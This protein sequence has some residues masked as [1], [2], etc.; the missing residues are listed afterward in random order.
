M[1]AS[2]RSD[3]PTERTTEWRGR[4]AG[5]PARTAGW[6]AL[7]SPPTGSPCA[8]EPVALRRC[9]SPRTGWGTA[10]LDLPR[11]YRRTGR[12]ASTSTPGRRH[13]TARARRVPRSGSGARHPPGLLSGGREALLPTAAGGPL[14][15]R[16][17]DRTGRA[18]DRIARVILRSVAPIPAAP[19][20][21]RRVG[22]ARVVLS[23]PAAIMDED[24]DTTF[25]APER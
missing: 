6:T 22:G 11:W 12:G 7:P 5:R 17:R 15:G 23:V 18:R 25:E 13:D 3:N 14:A 20:G 24:A 21:L 1:T 19:R 9:G 16:A 4:T 10:I 8:L 2:R